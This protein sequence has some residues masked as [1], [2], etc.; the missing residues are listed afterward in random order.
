MTSARPPSAPGTGSSFGTTSAIAVAVLVLLV[1]S[2]GY[3]AFGIGPGI[4]AT[5]T[6]AVGIGAIVFG[7]FLC[8][9]LFV[10]RVGRTRGWF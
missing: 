3:V 4:G 8:V 9:A 1:G 6:S 10:W 2:L 5:G 7:L